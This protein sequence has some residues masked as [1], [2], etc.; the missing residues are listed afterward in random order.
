MKVYFCILPAHFSDS[1][2][3]HFAKAQVKQFF[4]FVERNGLCWFNNKTLINVTRKE[5]LDISKIA[6]DPFKVT[7]PKD[8]SLGVANGLVWCCSN[9]WLFPKPVTT[10]WKRREFRWQWKGCVCVCAR[11]WPLPLIHFTFH[12]LSRL[13]NDPGHLH[14]I[15]SL[16]SSFYLITCYSIVTNCSSH[17]SEL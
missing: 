12:F 1:E 11:V 4:H 10:K 3:S 15:S 7:V 13:S 5:P 6:L 16:H 2:I 8:M 14:W 17:Y 9:R